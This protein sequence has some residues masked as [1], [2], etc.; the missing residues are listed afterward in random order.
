MSRQMMFATSFCHEETDA[1]GV[2][3]QQCLVRLIFMCH[4]VDAE[5]F[6]V[7]LLTQVLL[8]DLKHPS[9]HPDLDLS[10]PKLPVHASVRCN[11]PSEAGA[12]AAY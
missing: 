1:R 12:Q 11:A 3:R 10:P 9:L 2:P 8:H 6:V 4:H 7:S 5:G